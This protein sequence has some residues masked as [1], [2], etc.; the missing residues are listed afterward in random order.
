MRKIIIVLLLSFVFFGCTNTTV[1]K[2]NELSLKHQEVSKT[3]FDEL[4]EGINLF[5]KQDYAAAA[6]QGEKCYQAFTQSKQLSEETKSLA[7]Q[8]KKDWLVQ[9]KD[10]S[11]QAED[12][13]IKQCQL[14]QEVATL[15]KNKDTQKAQQV[16]GQISDLNSTFNKLQSTMDDIKNQHPESFK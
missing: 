1:N 10:L 7:Q 2:Y 5:N 8:L 12:I 6:T 15:S 16:I 4:S 3:G 14:L 11:A 9:F 13:R